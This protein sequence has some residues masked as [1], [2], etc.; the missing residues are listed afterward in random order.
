MSGAE[1]IRLRAARVAELQRGSTSAAEEAEIVEIFLCTRGADLTALKN[2]IDAGGDH[3]D[4]QQLVFHDIDDDGRRAALLDH[5]AR[6]AVP[7]GEIKILSDIDDTIYANWKDGRYPKKTVYPGVLQLHKELDRGPGEQRG[8]S[9]DLTFVTARPGDRAGLVESLTFGTLVGLGVESATI[10]TGGLTSLLSNRSIARRKLES[11]HEYLKLYPE[12]GFVFI[13]DSG[14]GDIHFGQD[15]LAAAPLVVRIVLI[16]DVVATPEER[17]RE[18]A[19]GGVRLFDT[20]VGAAAEALSL[21][22]VSPAGAARV[23]HA[24]RADLAA[25][26]FDSEQQ[27]EA[28]RADLAR[29]IQRLDALLPEGHRVGAS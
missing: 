24:A 6:E 15:M 4:L 22:L 29:D 11:F 10:L 21:A 20:Y 27:A 3:L 16:H 19:Q 7:C 28:R 12:Y 14:Q 23:A 13:G 8:R 25:I 18:L 9:G 1:A 26:A 5:F 17:R 2:A